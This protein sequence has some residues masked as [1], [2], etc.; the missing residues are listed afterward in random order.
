M[1]DT[2]FRFAVL[3]KPFGQQRHRTRAFVTNRH[4]EPAAGAMAYSPEA[5]KVAK[6]II[7]IH[8]VAALRR[9][10][11]EWDI[12]GP[13]RVTITAFWKCGRPLVNGVRPAKWRPKKP[14]AD[15]IAKSV[16]DALN[17]VLFLDDNQ[18]CDLRV[19]KIEDTQGRPDRIEV[20]VERFDDPTVDQFFLDEI[21][22]NMKG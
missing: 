11:K 8:A 22:H 10:A 16:L 6:K 4:G 20:V 21:R 9:Y 5:N 14:D 15:N 3:M 13:M 19:L 12:N 1:A 17:G 18:I 2:V 7:Q